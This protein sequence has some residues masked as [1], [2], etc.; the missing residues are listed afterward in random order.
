MSVSAL[1]LRK[2]HE[3]VASLGSWRSWKTSV[4]LR[5]HVLSGERARAEREINESMLIA[6]SSAD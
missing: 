6:N 5:Q 3:F 2:V 4:A 1:V